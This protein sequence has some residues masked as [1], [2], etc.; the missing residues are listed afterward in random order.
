MVSTLV[1][2]VLGLLGLLGLSGCVGPFGWD[3]TSVSLGWHAHGVLRR[4]A[5]L[6]VRGDGYRVGEPWQ[7]RESQFATDEVVET[8]VRVARA[9]Q[10]THPGGWLSIGDL[11]HRGG[12]GSPEHRS[13]QSGRDFDIFLPAVD[14]HGGMVPL[15]D[16]ML[17]FDR[18]GRAVAW[19]AARG[20]RAPARPVPAARLDAGRAWR[21]VRALLEDPGLEVQ[22]IFVQRDLAAAILREAGASDP[23]LVARAEVIVRQPSDSEPHDDHLHVRAFCDPGDR[24]LGCEDRGPVR[25][26]KKGWKHVAPPFEVGREPDVSHLLDGVVRQ[27]PPLA[28]APST[29]SS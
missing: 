24:A 23:A 26:L 16:C 13:H 7:A 3:G 19:S 27:R 6:P 15:G 9:V 5:R 14:A 18:T 10:R 12:G 22:W 8:V 20:G 11:S 2:A 28:P 25:W 29:P 17:H 1:C 21:V 4:P